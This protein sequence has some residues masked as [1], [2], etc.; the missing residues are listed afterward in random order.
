MQREE[1][2]RHDKPDPVTKSGLSFGM[3]EW[4]RPSGPVPHVACVWVLGR[5][6]KTT[7][8]KLKEQPELKTAAQLLGCKAVQFPPFV[9]ERGTYPL[10]QPQL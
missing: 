5:K 3:A 1:G 4:G 6:E 10:G 7:E 9:S 2:A 8:Q